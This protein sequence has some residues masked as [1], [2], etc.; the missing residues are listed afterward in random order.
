MD[1]LTCNMLLRRAVACAPTSHLCILRAVSLLRGGA[2]RYTSERG[3]ETK[4]KMRYY[5]TGAATLVNQG[6][7][8][9][10][11]ALHAYSYTTPALTAISRVKQVTSG[12]RAREPTSEP[13]IRDTAVYAIRGRP[14]PRALTA[15]TRHQGS[16][17]DRP[18]TQKR[19]IQYPRPV[20]GRCPFGRLH[21]RRTSSTMCMYTHH[22]TNRLPLMLHPRT[23]RRTPVSPSVPD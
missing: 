1:G 5:C 19:N 17:H 4:S 7:I 9:C 12:W 3:A 15:G 18:P 16:R 22:P 14:M 11:C 6:I 13:N 20:A 23:A 10:V 2:C 21:R 8:I